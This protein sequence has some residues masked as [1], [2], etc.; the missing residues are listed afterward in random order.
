MLL[1]GILARAKRN[2]WIA[3]NP[4]ED[5]D[6]IRVQV[7][8]EFNILEP[9]QVEAIARHA[10]TPLFAALIRTGAY[11]GLRCPGELT[12]LRWEHLDFE[13]RI[14]HVRRNY[15]LGEEGVTKGKHVRSVPMADQAFV[16]LDALSR[17]EHYTAPTDLVFGAEA[18]GHLSGAAIR[19]ELYEA[20]EKAGLGHLR[21]K[22]DPIIPYDLRHT[23]GS[24]AVRRAPLSDVQSWMG[25]RSITTTM[26][27]I[28]YLP[29]EANAAL[30]SE[31]FAG[32]AVP[33][34]PE[35]PDPD[36]GKDPTAVAPG[37]KG[38]V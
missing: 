13:N 38:R 26:R 6:K 18:G 8:E 12:A 30:L 35:T 32:N 4:A 21:D 2:R 27:Y 3:T 7:G 15:V 36:E 25:H 33:D 28:H 34:A 23:F 5:A 1:H 10:S 22:P 20:L 19:A 37:R 24:L 29:Q 31:V 11:T 17:R 9:E 16:A 14:V